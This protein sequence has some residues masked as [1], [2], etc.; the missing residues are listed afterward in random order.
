MY[1]NDLIVAIE[2][3]A[4]KAGSRGEIKIYIQ[5]V[6][7]DACGRRRGDIISEAPEGLQKLIEEAL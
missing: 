7:I 1:I 3:A 2:E 6:G 5:R 4:K